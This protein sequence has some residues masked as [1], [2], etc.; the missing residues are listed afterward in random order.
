MKIKYRL[1][2]SKPLFSFSFAIL[3]SSGLALIFI[4]L[5]NNHSNIANSLINY[6]SSSTLIARIAFWGWLPIAETLLCLLGLSIYLLIDYREHK[7]PLAAE[8]NHVAYS[9]NHHLRIVTIPKTKY[10]WKTLSYGSSLIV[11]F[12]VVLLLTIAT[13]GHRVF[14]YTPNDFVTTWKTDNPG[15]SASNQI[16]IP[17]NISETYNYTIDWGDGNTDSNVT[18]S[19]T[20]TYATSGTYT[21]AI[22]GTFPHFDL[23][24]GSG[25]DHDKILTVEQWGTNPWTSMASAFI[26]ATNLTVTATDS[27]D[28]SNVTSMNS[29]FF[30]AKSFNSNINNWDVS[31]VT[32]MGGMFSGASAFNQPLDNWD[33]SNAV[34]LDGVFWGAVAFNQP[35][36]NW[37]V[38]NVTDMSGMFSGASAFNQPLDTWD[39]SG[40]TNTSGMF[41]GASAFNQPLDTWDVSGVIDMY[42]MF[43]G[44]SAFNQPLDTW[45]VSGVTSLNYMFGNANAFLEQAFNGIPFANWPLKYQQLYNLPLS[46]LSTA[47]YDSTLIAWSSLPLQNNVTF[48]GGTSKYCTSDTQRQ[49]II[50]NH[51]WTINDSGEDCGNPNPESPTV[52]TAQNTDNSSTPTVKTKNNPKYK[53]VNS[54]D[55]TG[56]PTQSPTEQQTQES[57]T[58]PTDIKQ[59]ILAPEAKQLYV[60]YFYASLPKIPYI[61]IIILLVLSTIY[62]LQAWRSYRIMKNI[63]AL[64][65]IFIKTIQSTKNFVSITSHYLNTPITIMSGSIELLE[66]QKD[67]IDQ[68]IMENIKNY[69]ATIKLEIDNALSSRSI[70]VE[71]LPAT[72][73]T[74][75]D[76]KLISPIKSKLFWITVVISSILF[77][78]AQVLLINNSLLSRSGIRV[79]LELLAFIVI[80]ILL[81]LT[82]K[83]KIYVNN[84]IV[85]DSQYMSVLSQQ[86]EA[87][88]AFLS[89]TSS[90]VYY[91]VANLKKYSE[92]FDDLAIA[93]PFINGIN[94]LL[95]VCDSTAKVSRFSAPNSSEQYIS[96]SN[97]TNSVINEY[98]EKAQPKQLNIKTSI[99]QK[100]D[101]ESND[102]EL[103]HI[104]ESSI[105]NSIKFSQPNGE[106]AIELI[107]HRNNI[108]LT[109][110]DTGIGI[111]PNKIDTLFKP[112]S[113]ATNTEEYDYE[114]LGL[115]LN[116][117]KIIV[118]KLGG[119]ITVA[120][121][122][123]SGLITKISLP[124][125]HPEYED[126]LANHNNIIK[127]TDFS[128]AAVAK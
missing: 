105:D 99:A 85:L 41:T 125:S 111:D 39:V 100:I 113:R 33:V 29:M 78:T 28:L 54:T 112:F 89:S 128:S 49:S 92:D 30:D 10:Y 77:A 35:L 20:H 13:N 3:L 117:T 55:P 17:T 66:I 18:G 114:G 11:C 16:T 82:Y 19:I 87:Q 1:K 104:I 31:N 97:I 22:N 61:L 122:K 126:A 58:V 7:K 108:I 71:I 12:I 4:K 5:L 62:L 69:M 43:A 83:Y 14:A 79:I 56:S 80:C 72:Q 116:V 123:P 15:S 52:V 81:I 60:K 121:S 48:D 8:D 76:K 93:K 46:G 103:R 106:I 42:G 25:G 95:S 9:L 23:S 57:G 88:K 44:A 70:N 53:T 102:D 50:D 74:F 34:S 124:L 36:K 47:N 120:N 119:F 65:D 27:P 45:D 24:D 107:K 98:R 115:S 96:F 21:V 38:S 86:S 26:N 59:L 40:I 51:T 91:C 32:S 37:D 90:N 73:I 118:E 63:N 109:I 6:S 94:M 75:L 127:P 84:K 2:L 101:I 68:E 64:T 67:N 110:K